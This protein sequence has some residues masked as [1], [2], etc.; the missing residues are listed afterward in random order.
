[1]YHEK[2]LYTAIDMLTLSQSS[3]IY[4]F[5]YFG[6]VF[7]NFLNISKSKG[8][9]INITALKNGMNWKP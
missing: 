6:E 5:N 2:T 8:I 9:K 4:S 7:S 3:E 1:V